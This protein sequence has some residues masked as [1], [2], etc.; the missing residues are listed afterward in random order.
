MDKDKILKIHAM[1]NDIKDNFDRDFEEYERLGVK[2]YHTQKRKN[3]HKEA[4]FVICKEICDT[5]SEDEWSSS[6]RLKERMEELI[7]N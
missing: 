1:L 5:M 4:I 2:P 7:P 3:K 6:G